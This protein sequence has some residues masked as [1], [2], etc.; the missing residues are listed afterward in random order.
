VQ[1]VREAASSMKCSNHLHQ[2]GLAMHGFHDANGSF[3]KGASN[4]PRQTWVMYLWPYVEQNAL[5]QN[6]N[7]NNNFYDA[8]GT[9][10]GTMNGVCGARVPIYLCPS[11]TGNPDQNVGTYQRTRG[12]YVVNWGNAYYDNPSPTAG[13][14]PFYHT[15]GNRSSPG[16][17]TI[18]GITDGT[19]NTL[20]LSEYL[21]AKSPQ[22]NDWR[23]DIHNDDGVFRFHT[24]MTPNTTAPDQI[25]GGW[26]QTPNDPLMPATTAAGN[27]QQNTARSRHTGGVNVALGDASVRFVRNTIALDTW[28]KLGTMDGG[29]TPGDF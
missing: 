18:V 9:V 29:E 12:N 5:A 13:K 19:T 15:N 14:A 2:W 25:S 24:I 22:D 8:P 1:K 17:T 16:K 28:Q 6:N 7:L 4:N 26:F 3:P 20:L 10:V 27:Q 11:D 23:G 21:I